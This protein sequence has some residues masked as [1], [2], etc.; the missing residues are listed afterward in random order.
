MT[1]VVLP[2]LPLF[3]VGVDAQ[4]RGNAVGSLGL[5][6]TAFHFD[7]HAVERPVEK[8]VLTLNDRKSRGAGSVYT[9]DNRCAP[10]IREMDGIAVGVL[11]DGVYRHIPL[12]GLRQF[13]KRFDVGVGV[14]Y[15]LFHGL[16]PVA[17]VVHGA[18]QILVVI[19]TTPRCKAQQ[20]DCQKGK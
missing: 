2:H 19:R 9:V 7:D 10:A 14:F 12:Q 15:G 20:G 13:L 6:L 11:D 5:D 17:E 16:H 18:P 3:R 1:M 4:L 8:P